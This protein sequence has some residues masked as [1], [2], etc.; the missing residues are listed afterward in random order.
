VFAVDVDGS[1]LGGMPLDETDAQ[2]LDEEGKED[3]GHKNG[4]GGGLELELTQ[5]FVAEHEDGMSEQLVE[6]SVRLLA[7]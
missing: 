3:T 1:L 4:G 5:A 6:L 7:D 2:V